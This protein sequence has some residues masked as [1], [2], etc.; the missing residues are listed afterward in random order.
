M[1]AFLRLRGYLGFKI[2]NVRS[3]GYLFLG[4]VWIK[5]LKIQNTRLTWVAFLRLGLGYLGLSK[6]CYN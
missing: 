5:I 1:L 6:K 2:L 4:H 3:F